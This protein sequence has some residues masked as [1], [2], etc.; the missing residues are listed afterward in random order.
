LRFVV[1]AWDRMI[2]PGLKIPWG[3]KVSLTS[4]K[5]SYRVCPNILTWKGDRTRPSPCSAER[6]P[7]ISRTNPATSS[8]MLLKRSTPPTVFRFTAGRIWRRPTEAWA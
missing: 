2:F 7:P 1:R 6:A 4:Q 8:A 5:A 3:S